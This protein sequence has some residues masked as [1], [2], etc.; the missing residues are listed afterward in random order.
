MIKGSFF[1]SLLYLKRFFEFS[2]VSTP[3]TTTTI[4]IIVIF[5]TEGGFFNEVH[6]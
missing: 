1:N 6:L 4:I 2:I 5:Y 3:P